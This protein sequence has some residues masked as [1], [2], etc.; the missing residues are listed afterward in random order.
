MDNL[1]F[2][3]VFIYFILHFKLFYFIISVRAKYYN[4][5]TRN[6]ETHNVHKMVRN[7]R[8][9]MWPRELNSF[10]EGPNLC[11]YEYNHFLIYASSMCSS[12]VLGNHRKYTTSLL[13]L[14]G[15]HIDDVSDR[16]LG[17]R[18]RDVADNTSCADTA[19]CSDGM[20]Y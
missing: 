17:E 12:S 4:L 8:L 16:K 18:L 2:V 14:F 20:K 6:A 15:S 3:P 1:G 11:L 10:Q 9:H 5:Y 7:P 19:A 13:R